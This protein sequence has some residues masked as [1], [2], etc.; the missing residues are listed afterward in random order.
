MLLN[1]AA[2][3]FSGF[4]AFSAA[5]SEFAYSPSGLCVAGA[6]CL[7]HAKGLVLFAGPA[8]QPIPL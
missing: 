5:P 6:A 1:S 7:A 4:C 8:E 2:Q 3:S